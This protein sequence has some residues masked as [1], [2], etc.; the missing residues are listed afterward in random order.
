[1]KRQLLPAVLPVDL[2]QARAELVAAFDSFVGAL[3]AAS[4]PDELPATL[5]AAQAGKLIG[6]HPSTVRK[7]VD[8]GVLVPLPGFSEL[9]LSKVEVERYA[10]GEPA[11]R[12]GVVS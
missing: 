5:T 3:L 11:R 4:Q 2:E 6:A 1:M 8:A 9:R 10:A 7:M 12:L